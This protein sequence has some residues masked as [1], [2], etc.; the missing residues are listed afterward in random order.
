MAASI[1]SRDEAEGRLESTAASGIVEEDV[2]GSPGS[3]KNTE[4]VRTGELKREV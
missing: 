3:N 1:S 4:E 2:R